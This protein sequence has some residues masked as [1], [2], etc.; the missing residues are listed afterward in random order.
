MFCVICTLGVLL[1]LQMIRQSIEEKIAEFRANTGHST[2]CLF[3]N[4]PNC[5]TALNKLISISNDSQLF[6]IKTLK[7]SMF[8]LNLRT[9]TLLEMF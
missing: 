5:I 2:A 1:P 3:N 6:P 7:L 4:I 8:I 9:P